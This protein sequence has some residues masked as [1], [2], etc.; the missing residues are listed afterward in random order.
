MPSKEDS[1]PTL[2]GY[3]NLKPGKAPLKFK[4]EPKDA[5]GS[6]V[7]HKTD[8]AGARA[9]RRIPGIEKAWVSRSR[10]VILWKSGRMEKFQ[11]PSSLQK[12]VDKF[13]A[14]AG[15]FPPGEYILKPLDKNNLPGARHQYA[16]AGVKVR[17]SKSRQKPP[18]VLR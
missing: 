8:C 7:A 17:P 9:L 2:R 5:I 18:H 16:G 12:A 10:T 15:M 3:P 4:V 6:R 13:D 1:M 11:N 14:T